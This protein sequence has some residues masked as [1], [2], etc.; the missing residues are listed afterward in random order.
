MER[1]GTIRDMPLRVGRYDVIAPLGTGGM[2]T[3]YL[4]RDATN[5]G[6]DRLVA[7]KV[8]HRH[9]R[10]EAGPGPLATA[11]EFAGGNA[12]KDG[13]AAMPTAARDFLREASIAAR[14]KHSNVV[15]VLECRD[16]PE[17]LYLVMSY[18]EGDAIAAL[19][20][21]ALRSGVPIPCGVALRLIVDTLRGLHAAHELTTPEGRPLALIHRDVTPQNVLVGRNGV[22]Q[23]MDFGVARLAERTAMSADGVVKGKLRYMAPEQLVGRN[24]DRRV[25][26]WAAGIM[27]AE[28]LANRRFFEGQDDGLVLLA[29]MNGPLPDV[30]NLLTPPVPPVLAGIVARAIA[31]LPDDRFSTAADFADALERTELVAAHGDVARYVEGALGELFSLRDSQIRSARAHV[32]SAEFLNDEDVLDGKTVTH[33]RPLGMATS[34]STAPPAPGPERAPAA[35]KAPGALLAVGASIA[36][37]VVLGGAY[38]VARGKPPTM[39]ATEPA[40][41]TAAPVS[42][43]VAPEVPVSAASPTRSASVLVVASVPLATLERLRDGEKTALALPR[44]ATRIDLSDARPGDRIHAES[45]DGR[46]LD[47]EVP[48]TGDLLLTF[49]GPVKARTAPTARTTNRDGL[50]RNFP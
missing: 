42:T 49:T 2:A 10:E 23:L 16:E 5:V 26:V 20:R 19:T 28:L 37:F 14:I 33:T 34:P 25:D 13:G 24:M 1:S 38:A 15:E 46:S 18:V 11:R 8:L 3:V 4:A 27:L 6:F 35:S 50:L 29:L 7:V 30:A 32:E 17:A 43:I 9:L 40:K 31:R 41:V 48:A 12:A 22:S 21:R 47:V 45:E 44:G 39:T 36:A